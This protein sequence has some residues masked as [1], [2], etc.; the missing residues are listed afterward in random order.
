M[1]WQRSFTSRED[2]PSTVELSSQA[3]GRMLTQIEEKYSYKWIVSPLYTGFEELC[4]FVA[5]V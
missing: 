2:A 3:P 4:I 1:K 5:F